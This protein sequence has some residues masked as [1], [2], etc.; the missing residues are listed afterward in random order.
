MHKRSFTYLLGTQTMSNAADILYIM[1]L[2][3]L[4]FHETD[5]IFSSVLVPL[6][7]MGA[8]MISGFLAPLILARF[9]L[10]FI[11]FVSHFGVRKGPP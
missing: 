3:S 1:A 4:V 10:P 8:Q 9:Q 7:R 11:L 2:V 5:S 6:L